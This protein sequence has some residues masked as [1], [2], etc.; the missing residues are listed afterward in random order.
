MAIKKPHQ[1]EVVVFCFIVVFDITIVAFSESDA[2][3]TRA[4]F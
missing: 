4:Q 1:F 2:N 3:Q